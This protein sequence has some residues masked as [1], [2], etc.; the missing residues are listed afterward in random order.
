M[1]S[2]M[3]HTGTSASR[4]LLSG[5]RVLDLTRILA[6]PFATQL[7]GDY[8]ADIL[9]VEHPASGDDTRTWGPPF[10]KPKSKVEQVAVK[11]ESCYFLSVNRN[12]RSVALDLKNASH[13]SVVQD[14]A[15]LADVVI[16][17]YLPGKLKKFGLDYDTLANSNPGMVY[18]E[19]SGWGSTGPRSH[20]PGYDVIASAVG[21][22]MHVTGTEEGPPVKAGVAITDI[23][24]GLYASGAIMGALYARQKD[25]RGERIECSLFESQLSVLANLA[26]NALNADLPGKRMG[27][28]H[29]SIVPYQVFQTQDGYITIAA[30]N[31]M[32]F[33]ALC[34]DM[35]LPFLLSDPRFTTNPLR[36]KNRG[37]LLR[38]MCE[39]LLTRS[40]GEWV[41]HFSS[42][43]RDSG[44]FSFG[45]INNV[46][47]AFQDVQAQS[48]DMVQRV[49]HS[50]LGHVKL[51]GFAVKMAQH[52]ASTTRG[53]P[54]LGEHTVA[55][56]ADWLDITE[57]EALIRL[58]HP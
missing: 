10:L 24:T 18:C 47:E 20:E 57:A 4:G 26:S 52:P 6:G 53:P 31:D 9:K 16:H 41:D 29:A 14:L 38:I 3:L 55:A 27:T 34:E 37:E 30:M 1:A 35:E 56:I 48:R 43:Q 42:R 44:Q 13:L 50:T 8:G 36:V 12:K 45:P 28:A 58:Q 39:K 17:N 33:S 46:V 15:S 51:P 32:Q 19:I 54:T 5:V 49:P 11:A 2:G 25:G 40:T 23:V 22:F 21:G 7:L